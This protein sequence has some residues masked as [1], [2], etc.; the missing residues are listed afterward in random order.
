MTYG[1]CEN[2]PIVQQQNLL[3]MGLA[4]GCRLKRDIPKDQVLTYDD[5]ELPEGRLCDKL[6]AE[7]AVYFPPAKTLALTK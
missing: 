7:Q 3:P 4:E 6:R 2:S 1:Q 5:V